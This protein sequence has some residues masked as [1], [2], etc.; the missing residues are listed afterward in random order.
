MWWARDEWSWW[1]WGGMSLGMVAFWVLVVWAV[2][3]ILRRSRRQDDDA[4]RVRAILDERHARGEI[5]DDEYRTRLDMLRL[6]TS[7]PPR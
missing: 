5:D 6:A 1:E 4:M 7:D 3:T 2:A